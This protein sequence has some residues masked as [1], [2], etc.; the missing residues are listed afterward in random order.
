MTVFKLV[1]LKRQLSQGIGVLLVL[2]SLFTVSG[3]ITPSVINREKVLT[4]GSAVNYQSVYRTRIFYRSFL[5]HAQGDLLQY[6]YLPFSFNLFV[7]A[8]DTL[9]QTQFQIRQYLGLL[10]NR[11][12]NQLLTKMPSFFS[13]Y[14]GESF[15]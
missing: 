6:I 2:I 4:T 13:S 11:L 14:T 5:Q 7:S 1:D 8:K 9:V 15:G 10:I 12:N 3:G